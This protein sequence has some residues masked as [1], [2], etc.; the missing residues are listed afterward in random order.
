M[1]FGS[2]VAANTYKSN[3]NFSQLTLAFVTKDMH[4]Q[5]I[6]PSM[7]CVHCTSNVYVCRH[8][9]TLHAYPNQHPQAAKTASKRNYQCSQTLLICI[10]PIL[11]MYATAMVVNIMTL[12]IV[13]IPV[14][15]PCTSA[16]VICDQF[17]V[18]I[19]II[20][21]YILKKKAS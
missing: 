18:C 12:T 16:F 11:A 17:C 20:Y 9:N 5:H 1:A 21:I 13:M 14:L 2:P 6:I 15:S 8:Q 19:Y 4:Y 3:S 7:Q 10:L